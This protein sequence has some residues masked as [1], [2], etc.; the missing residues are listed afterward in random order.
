ML[1]LLFWKSTTLNYLFLFFLSEN[2]KKAAEAKLHRKLERQAAL[3]ASK[4][5]KIR[6]GKKTVNLI[7][8][9]K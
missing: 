2:A 3:E 7:T 4:Q 8:D 6:K 9:T 5:A 1:L